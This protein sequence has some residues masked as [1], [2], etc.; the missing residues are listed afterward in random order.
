MRG[1]AALLYVLAPARALANGRFPAVISAT[2]QD[3]RIAV[4]ST[5]GMLVSPDGGETWKWICEDAI[6]YSGIWDPDISIES[7]TGTM[8]AT[9]SH[10]VSVSEDG[11]CTWEPRG[12]AWVSDVEIR[13]DL[14][15]VMAT[16]TGGTSNGIFLTS[17]H[18]R[19]WEPSDLAS[20]T[21]FYR[22][23]ALGPPERAW[24]LGYGID[25]YVSTVSWSDDFGAT[26]SDACF[27]PDET[28]S[29]YLLGADPAA[30]DVLWDKAALPNAD[31]VPEW[32][33]RRSDAVACT[34]TEV[35]PEKVD[36]FVLSEDGRT[37]LA[38]NADDEGHVWRSVD[39][40][41]AFS[42]ATPIRAQ[43]FTR[44]GDTVYACA[45]NWEDGFAL[46]R[47]TDWGDTWEG[48]M[49]FGDISGVLE[50]AA[51]TPTHDLCG[52][53][54]PGLC[55]QLG[56]AGPGCGPPPGDGGADGDPNR[57]HGGC[58]CDETASSIVLSGLFFLV[59]AIGRRR[60]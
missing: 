58:G 33:L 57:R 59:A 1:F 51:G 44:D 15:W 56:L 14:V 37:V 55:D 8:V 3:G 53:L 23:I 16:A 20:D 49:R 54:F 43:S 2:A 39:G 21:D 42:E 35:L 41:D 46:G 34:R 47:S 18:A 6:G 31:G 19:T 22:T 4:G 10:G 5:F 32:R 17:D 12:D 28:S 11:G 13:P 52:P 27:V 25:P 26:W 7:G 38:G 29:A 40:G 36:A 60:Q 30:P 50:C 48:V 24:V 9:L 45:D